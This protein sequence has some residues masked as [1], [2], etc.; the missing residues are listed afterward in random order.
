MCIR[1]DDG[2]ERLPHIL[3][4]WYGKPCHAWH[5]FVSAGLLCC[6]PNSNMTGKCLCCCWWVFF[7]VTLPI[8]FLFGFFCGI[9][10]IF[11]DVATLLVWVGTCA[12]C[13]RKC[14]W[15][16]ESCECENEGVWDEEHMGR[17]ETPSS[18]ITCCCCDEEAVAGPNPFKD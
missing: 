14:C 6:L 1:C 8:N 17:C 12:F 15:N 7:I 9:V 2:V 4:C 11:L 3:I 13:W 10:G 5:C 16:C 18:Y